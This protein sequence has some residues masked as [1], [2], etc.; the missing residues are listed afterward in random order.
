MK[1]LT[2]FAAVLIALTF[3]ACDGNRSRT[4]S[5]ENATPVSSPDYATSPA[6]TTT[7][8]TAP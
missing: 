2:A 6:P 3:A 1:P 5:P 7:P 8:L 4:D